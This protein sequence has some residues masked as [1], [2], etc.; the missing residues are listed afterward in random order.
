M[1]LPHEFREKSTQTSK[2]TISENDA[3]DGM[4]TWIVLNSIVYTSIFIVNLNWFRV[5]SSDIRLYTAFKGQPEI[6]NKS[7]QGC[8]AEV[9]W[10]TQQYLSTLIYPT[11]RKDIDR[12]SVYW[13]QQ[14]NWTKLYNFRKIGVVCVRIP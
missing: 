2:T 11:H 3:V 12:G 5:E 13:G 1:H 9:A 4:N 14:A 8:Y 10:A 6:F 7:I